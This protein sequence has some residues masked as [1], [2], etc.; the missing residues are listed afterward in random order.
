M[1]AT[2]QKVVELGELAAWVVSR[3]VLSWELMKSIL[4]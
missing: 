2:G 1:Q 3:Q 4:P